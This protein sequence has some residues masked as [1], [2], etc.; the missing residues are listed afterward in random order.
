[1]PTPSE[2][3]TADARELRDRAAI[4]E[5][6]GR[7]H[8]ADDWRAWAADKESLAEAM[9]TLEKVRALMDEWDRRATPIGEEGGIDGYPLGLAHG[10]AE[11][12]AEAI[13]DLESALGHRAD[14]RQ[15]PTGDDQ[16]GTCYANPQHQPGCWCEACGPGTAVARMREE[17]GA[18]CEP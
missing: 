4:H 12:L 1:M 15:P 6:E 14:E 5:R 18:P 16:R 17:S 3:L 7:Q 10:K 13:A 8:T 2:Q 9:D 11:G